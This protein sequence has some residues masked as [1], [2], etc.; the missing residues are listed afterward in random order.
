MKKPRKSSAVAKAPVST[1]EALRAA[2]QGQFEAGRYREAIAAY[3]DLLKVEDTPQA[4]LELAGAYAGRARELAA[5]G[6]P[7]EALTIWEN[8]AP[9]VPGLPPELDHLTLLLRLGRVR[10]VA[11]LYAH[12]TDRL[13]A[14]TLPALRSHLAAQ[15]L[16]GESAVAAVVPG[17]DPILVHGIAASRAL[18][19]YARGDDEALRE[20]LAAIP[21]RSP[22]RDLAQI[23]KALQRFPGSPAEA[24]GLLAKVADD[25]GFAP[26]R[27]ACELGLCARETLPERLSAVGDPTRR[28]ALTLAGWGEQRQ[29]LWEEV[30]SIGDPGPQALLRLLH[31]HRARLGEAWARGQALRLLVPGFPKSAAWIAEGGG[32][33]LA[34]DERLLVTAWRAEEGRNPGAIV[35]AWR[36]YARHLLRGTLPELGSDEA[37]RVALVLRRPD[38]HLDILADAPPSG[39]PQALDSDLARLV[40]ASLDHDPDDRDSHERL[41]RYYLRGKDLKT[42]RRLL[43]RALGRLPKDAGLLTVAL[44]V[45][46][47]G[48]S[49]KK[50]ARYA[51][52]ILALDPINTGAR[53]CLVRAHLA[54]ARKQMRAGRYDLAAKELDQASAWDQASHLGERRT[55]LAGLVD[56]RLA[57]QRGRQS[58]AAL[59][60]RL[61]SGMSAALAVEL[62][63]SAA[64]LAAAEVLKSLGLGRPRVPEQAELAA[65]LGRLRAHLDAG[66]PIGAEV[67]RR[68]DKPLSGAA[69][70]PLTPGEAEAACETLRR[71][72]LPASRLAFSE[73]ALG[74]WPKHPVFVLHAFEARYG[75]R[76][77]MARTA[78][79]ERVAAA[80]TAAREAGDQRS[81]LRAQEILADFPSV[82][83]GPPPCGVW[84][85]DDDT[86]DPSGLADLPGDPEEILR[87]FVAM[88]GID[89]LLEMAGASRQERAEIKRL[90]RELGRDGAIDVLTRMLRDRLPDF[91][92][93]G[94][95]SPGRRQE[96]GRGAPQGGGSPG[97]RQEPG[98]DAPASGPPSPS[99]RPGPSGRG[100]PATGT[101]G[102][103]PGSSRDGDD[104]PQQL[105]FFEAIPR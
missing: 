18:D 72:G 62:E 65:V 95:G 20:S 86:G 100:T 16:G 53:E 3:K 44:D 8:R 30:R 56:L 58:L 57:P 90:E 27:R 50:A 91:A 73:S 98:R 23:L 97:R 6:M 32:R 1:P 99:D 21:F 81:V 39:D 51:H 47:A 11:D 94:G 89:R 26:L 71:A 104:G 80:L 17:D 7:K 38:S 2:A 68:F 49:F 60:A 77:R 103:R 69:H 83:G 35:E 41:I 45:A 79:L 61:G 74:R 24:P 82:P 40:E 63:C 22:Y 85:E 19:A 36:A 33:R 37:L 31:R 92:P 10:A 87:V 101:G 78:D 9:L 5:K 29:S 93:Q 4:R 102:A 34:E 88:L 46:L 54:H 96:P 75:Q 43:D 12:G 13:A 42:A 48:D 64:G 14:A 76:P 105:D 15:H 28:F 59:V 55:L 52:E 84:D 67:R 70:L 66:E 25:S